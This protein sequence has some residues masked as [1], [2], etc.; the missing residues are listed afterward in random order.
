M[1]DTNGR[2]TGMYKCRDRSLNIRDRILIMGILNVTPDSFSD[3]GLYTSP[4]EA[5]YHATQMDSEGADIIDVGGES[6][7]PGA[8]PVSTSEELA[9]VV[10][11]I[12]AIRSRSDIVISVDTYKSEVAEAALAA[13]ADI[14]NDI[15]GL[16]KDSAMADVIAKYGAGVIVMYNSRLEGGIE[17]KPD[18]DVRKSALD[19][20]TRS[21][22]L[23]HRAGISDDRIMT[24][25]GIGFGTS[26]QQDLVLTSI[27]DDIGFG[28]RYPVCYGASRKR[29]A[30]VLMQQSET[31]QNID[32]VSIG[33]ALAGAMAGAS[34]VRVH[35]V[36]AT[37]AA[38]NGN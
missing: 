24:D 1:T 26:R 23:A 9:R 12:K 22:E 16:Q 21:I 19:F 3:G 27:L 18:C 13:G 11:V 15:T 2:F 4:D 31:Q 34:V 10:P 5:L 36:R 25:P 8:E 17:N 20:L 35:E 7:R 29:I 33:L 38:L 32:S 37:D 6:T 28:G 14:I 30:K